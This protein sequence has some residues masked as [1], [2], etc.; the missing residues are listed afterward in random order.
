MT[1]PVLQ[2]SFEHEPVVSEEHQV[3][4]IGEA[5]KKKDKW[6][7]IECKLPH[8]PATI[9]LCMMNGVIDYGAWTNSDIERQGSLIVWAFDVR[10][11]EEFTLIKLPD[12]VSI[13]SDTDLVNYQRKVALVN[14]SYNDR[15]YMW[16]YMK[17]QRERVYLL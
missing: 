5:Q 7:K 3:F 10:C 17:N 1:V 15:F 13:D 9:G 2:V 8:C 12:G 16:D 11:E 6:R 4:T 14:I